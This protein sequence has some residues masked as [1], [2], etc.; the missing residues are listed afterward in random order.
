[1]IFV[2]LSSKY[3]ILIF[4]LIVLLAAYFWAPL[5]SPIVDYICKKSISN[6]TIEKSIINS[7]KYLVT[8]PERN[9]KRNLKIA[10]GYSFFKIINITYTVKIL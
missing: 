8:L 1:M 5:F 9:L 7:W 4:S 6:R 10:I 3:T 2:K